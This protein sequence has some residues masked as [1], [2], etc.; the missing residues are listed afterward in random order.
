MLSPTS[1]C[2]RLP[3]RPSR[4]ADRSSCST[5][6][7][8]CSRR[9][10]CS[11][12]T[13]RSASRVSRTVRRTRRQGSLRAARSRQPDGGAK[14][15]PHLTREAIREV[16]MKLA[17]RD[18]VPRDEAGV[19]HPTRPGEMAVRRR[20]NDDRLDRRDR[21]QCRGSCTRCYRPRR[22][23]P[24]SRG[25]GGRATSRSSKLLSGS[26]GPIADQG[27]EKIAGTSPSSSGARF[28]HT[29]SPQRRS[30]RSS[31]GRSGVQEP[32]CFSNLEKGDSP[33]AIN[34]W[35]SVRDM[36][37]GTRASRRGPRRTNARGGRPRSGTSPE[38]D[39]G[40]CRG[41]RP[42]YGATTRRP[43]PR[44]PA[45][46]WPGSCRPLSSQC[47][48]RSRMWPTA[49]RSRNQSAGAINTAS[50]VTL[51]YRSANDSE[52]EGDNGLSGVCRWRW[53]GRPG[54]DR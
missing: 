15:A 49:S 27:V 40:G 44:S 18:R 41:V 53:S 8:T 33:V 38:R 19:V 14:A 20:S 29:P 21:H 54:R 36:R 39:V 2:E 47:M 5:T 35:K 52:V 30:R 50:P 13:S 11:S 3:P 45:S 42:P 17:P 37:H 9:S 34:W 23:T 22:R 1:S 10:A 12:R 51:V 7:L 31:F 26:S 32:D 48:T 28:G 46:W 43:R 6:T 4:A 25:S 24:A 16:S